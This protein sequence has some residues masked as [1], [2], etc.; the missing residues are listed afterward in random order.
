[1]PAGLAGQVE[2]TVTTRTTG[3]GDGVGLRRGRYL[4]A[5]DIGPPNRTLRHVRT[6]ATQVDGVGLG[7]GLVG[8][9]VLDLPDATTS[10]ATRPA[11]TRCLHARLSFERVALV[12]HSDLPR[13]HLTRTV[14]DVTTG[15]ALG[16]AWHVVPRCDALSEVVRYVAARGDEGGGGD[17]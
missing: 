2:P 3:L 10:V 14:R 7:A 16:T 6:I 8:E 13:V 4:D 15:L 9:V 5:V 1:M 17:Q 11:A 12:D